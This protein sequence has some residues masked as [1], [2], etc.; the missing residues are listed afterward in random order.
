MA[1]VNVAGRLVVVK[2]PDETEFSSFKPLFATKGDVTLQYFV[3]GT[4]YVL[5]D[6]DSQAS[7]ALAAL[8]GHQE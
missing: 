2:G 3:G 4:G 6:E 1:G 5:Y 7:G 8:D